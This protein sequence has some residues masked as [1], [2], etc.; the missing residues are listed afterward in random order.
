VTAADYLLMDRAF[1]LHGGPLSPATLADREATFGSAYV[2]NLLA[3]V[4][5]PTAA[6]LALVS[7]APASMRRRRSR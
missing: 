1:A 3:S 6:T 7:L 5:E 4:P 2:A